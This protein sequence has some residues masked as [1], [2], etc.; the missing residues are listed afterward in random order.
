MHQRL[1]VVKPQDMY[2]P[3]L[4]AQRSIRHQNCGI[5]CRKEQ[6]AFVLHSRAL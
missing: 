2:F 3:K 6:S 5:P 1:G 4:L